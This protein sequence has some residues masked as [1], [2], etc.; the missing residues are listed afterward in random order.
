[1]RRKRRSNLVINNETRLFI[2]NLESSCE[3]VYDYHSCIILDNVSLNKSEPTTEYVPSQRYY[4]R[5]D[6]LAQMPGVVQPGTSSLNTNFTLD[7]S[8]LGKYFNSKC[9]FDMQVHIGECN[10]KP[11]EFSLFDKAII[12]KNVSIGSYNIDSIMS[13]KQTDVAPITE[14]VNFNFEQ[15]FE[16]KKPIFLEQT[17]D[18]IAAGPIIDS[19]VFCND[20][21]C[22]LCAGM[23]GKYYVQLV[24]CGEECNI[25]NLKTNITFSLWFD[26]NCLCE[27]FCGSI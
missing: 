6:I 20:V 11:N 2:Q 8:T 9:S 7:N 25:W 24:V 27:C 5:F 16:V 14:S 4:D 19:F 3:K 13:A 15:M 17:S 22:N 26:I 10:N 21:R 23:T 12:F 1:M 18:I